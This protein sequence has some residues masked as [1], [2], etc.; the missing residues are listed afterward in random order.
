MKRTVQKN[1]NA[2]IIENELCVTLSKI[3]TDGF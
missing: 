1:I 3:I 2:I